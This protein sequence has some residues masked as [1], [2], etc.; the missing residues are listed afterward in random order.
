MAALVVA[1]PA[2]V[3]KTTRV[4]DAVASLALRCNVVT[5]EKV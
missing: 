2:G 3:G 5:A 4:Y 1:G